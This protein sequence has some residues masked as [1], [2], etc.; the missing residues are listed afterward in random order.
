VA[1][2]ATINARV[3]ILRILI[4]L[5][6]RCRLDRCAVTVVS[7]GNQVSMGSSYQALRVRVAT[8]RNKGNQIFSNWN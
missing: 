3:I 5:T 8:G 4:L 7:G 6:V 1:V 2:A